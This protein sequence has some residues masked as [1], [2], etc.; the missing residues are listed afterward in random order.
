MNTVIC[1]DYGKKIFNLQIFGLK[2]YNLSHI[3]NVLKSSFKFLC[4]LE[5]LL[6]ILKLFF[7]VIEKGF[8]GNSF[9]F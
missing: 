8:V 3:I 9:F 7:V 6:K 4:S 2:N 1:M 5:L